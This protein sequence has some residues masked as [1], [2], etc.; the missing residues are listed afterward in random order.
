VK[1][2][3]KSD[4]EEIKEVL[5]ELNDNISRLPSEGVLPSGVT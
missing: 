3:K 4:I 1:A 5:I 2:K